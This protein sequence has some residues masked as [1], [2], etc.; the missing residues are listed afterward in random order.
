MQACCRINIVGICTEVSN[1]TEID[2][3][4]VH[5]RS[6]GF[7]ILPKI[8]QVLSGSHITH[9]EEM[10]HLDCS[11]E[12]YEPKKLT[13]SVLKYPV[14]SQLRAKYKLQAWLDKGWL[15]LYLKEELNLPKELILLIVI[16]QKKQ[17]KTKVHSIMDFQELNT[18][19]DSNT[20]KED[21]CME[22]LRE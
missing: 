19:V 9:R 20:V 18:Y 8:T 1:I 14:F 2:V 6:L 22:K 15:L 17:N 10:K 11:M 4:V 21:I 13:N 5:K 3:L 12:L 16:M 7:N